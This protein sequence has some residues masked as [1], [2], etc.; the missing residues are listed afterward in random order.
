MNTLESLI[1]QHHKQYKTY[2][3][4]LLSL[5]SGSLTFLISFNSYFIRETVVSDHCNFSPVLYKLSLLLFFLSS[6]SGVWLQHLLKNR[7]L[8]A[9]NDLIGKYNDEPDVEKKKALLLDPICHSPSKL[10]KVAYLCQLFLF[11]L[12]FIPLLCSV[13]IMV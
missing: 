6:A 7:Y 4:L 8:N 5:S 11:L 2:I 9:A 10:E 3:V 1:D 12:A 13:M